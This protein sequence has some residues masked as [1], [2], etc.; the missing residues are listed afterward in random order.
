MRKEVVKSLIA[1][2]QSEN[3]FNVINVVSAWKWLL[4]NDWL[5]LRMIKQE[6][7]Q[8]A[9]RG[10]DTLLHYIKLYISHAWIC[11]IPFLEGNVISSN[12][13]TYFS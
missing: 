3:P 9:R 8:G 5:D 7:T 2:K 10:Y 13:T 1:I 11:R 6:N 4:Q 12:V